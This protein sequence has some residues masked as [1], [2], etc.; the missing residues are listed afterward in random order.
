MGVLDVQISQIFFNKFIVGL[1]IVVATAI[2]M[3]VGNSMIKGYFTLAAK[4]RKNVNKISTIKRVVL[5]I[6]KLVILFVS[7][8]IF[9]DSVLGI[10]TTSIITVAGVSGVA[11]GFASQTLI[12]DLIS[13]IMLLMEDNLTIGDKVKVGVYEGIVEDINLRTISVR[14]THSLLHVIP[15]NTIKDFSNFSR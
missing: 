2:A 7:I 8:T 12:Q 1:I 5:N 4:T 6:Y 3:T 15:N 9:M 13:G 11:I 10:D 14:D